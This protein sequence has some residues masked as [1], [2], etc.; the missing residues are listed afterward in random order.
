MVG[1]TL[2]APLDST[3]STLPRPS[4]LVPPASRRELLREELLTTVDMLHR[5]RADLV[6]H[7]FIEDYVALRWLEWNGGALRLTAAGDIMCAQMRE[8]VQ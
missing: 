6:A 3:S 1:F 8:R 7:G 5:R 4:S 2:K